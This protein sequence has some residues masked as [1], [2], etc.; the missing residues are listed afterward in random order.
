MHF[1]YSLICLLITFELTNCYSSNNLWKMFNN[2]PNKRNYNVCL[3]QIQETK[4]LPINDKTQLYR[5]LI[6]EKEIGNFLKLVES[7]NK[8]AADLCFNLFPPFKGHVQYIEVFNISI[9]KL[10]KNNTEL[11]LSLLSEYDNKI[12]GK[13][14]S[15]D[16]LLG[17]YG[18]EFVDKTEK[19]IE[20]TNKRI[21]CLNEIKNSKYKHLINKC[22][23]YYNKRLKFLE[24]LK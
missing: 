8:Y 11:F 9:G 5:Q 14:T 20:E 2:N 4:D 10:I 12:I 19:K 15:F 18:S 13:Y 23:E 22:L 21:E 3:Q 7:G 6:I 16:G 1:K 24:Q 17:S